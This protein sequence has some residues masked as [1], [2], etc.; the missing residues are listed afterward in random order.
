MSEDRGRKR[1]FSR[2]MVMEAVRLGWSPC[3]DRAWLAGPDAGRE[4]GIGFVGRCPVHGTTGQDHEADVLA[5]VAEWPNED[6]G[7]TLWEDDPLTPDGALMDLYASR[8][9]H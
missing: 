3:C 5:W 4:Y 9:L 2:Y 6:V 8:R 1:A 7:P